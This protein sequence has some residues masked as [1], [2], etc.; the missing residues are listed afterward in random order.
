MPLTGGTP[1]SVNPHQD[2]TVIRRLRAAGAILI[3][4]T[5][6]HELAFG[7]LSTNSTHGHVGCAFDVNKFAGGSSGGGFFTGL[8]A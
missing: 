6:L 5:N 7:I 2:C 8:G 4:K 3:G 1:L